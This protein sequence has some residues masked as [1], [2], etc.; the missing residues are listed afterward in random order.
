MALQVPAP[1]RPIKRKLGCQHPPAAP[2]RRAATAAQVERN[3]HAIDDA[4][5][6]SHIS[7]LELRPSSNPLTAQERLQAVLAKGRAKVCRDSVQGRA[8][9]TH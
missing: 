1:S 2:C 3:R 6:A 9:D 4:L 8:H 5:V 7:C